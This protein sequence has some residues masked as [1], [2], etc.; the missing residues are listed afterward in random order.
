MHTPGPWTNAKAKRL[1][2]L[3]DLYADGVPLTADDYAELND[4]LAQENAQFA[5]EHA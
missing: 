3:S 5:A 2:E 4:L 1:A